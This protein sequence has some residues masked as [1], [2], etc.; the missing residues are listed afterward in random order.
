LA[1]FVPRILA[2][3]LSPLSKALCFHGVLVIDLIK[4]ELIRVREELKAK[5]EFELKSLSTN[6]LTKEYTVFGKKYPLIAWSEEDPDNS[7]VVIIEMRKKH[8]LGSFT[9]Y[10]QGFRYKQGECINLSEEQIWEYD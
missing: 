6:M 8:F 1:S 9:C 7:T 3:N 4:E 2:N 5:T 10:Q